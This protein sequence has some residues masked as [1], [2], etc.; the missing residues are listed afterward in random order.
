MQCT[1]CIGIY[2][3]CWTVREEEMDNLKAV[4]RDWVLSDIAPLFLSFLQDDS[5]MTT[6]ESAN[7]RNQNTRGPV[8]VQHIL[9][10]L[11]RYSIH[12]NTTAYFQSTWV[13]DIIRTIIV[14]VR[15]FVML[16]MR[17]LI[18]FSSNRFKC[19]AECFSRYCGRQVTAILKPSQ[20]R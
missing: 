20:M 12:Y 5:T 3:L 17:T 14:L 4:K 10:M 8:D 15:F 13:F 16:Y 19:A 2:S 7:A 18:L 9:L 11:I 6:S 1:G